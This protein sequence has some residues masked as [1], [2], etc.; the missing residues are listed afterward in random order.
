MLLSSLPH[1]SPLKGTV[2]KILKNYT[3]SNVMKLKK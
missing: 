3:G 1:S 2:C